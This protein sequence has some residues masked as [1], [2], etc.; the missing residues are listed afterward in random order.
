MDPAPSVR[1]VLFHIIILCQIDTTLRIIESI[2]TQD[3]L[4][5]VIG[6]I[7][8]FSVSATEFLDIAYRMRSQTSFYNAKK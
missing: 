2:I 5:F 7:I 1:L 8:R 3:N 6:I 4:D